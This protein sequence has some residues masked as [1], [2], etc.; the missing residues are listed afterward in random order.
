LVNV[1]LR[2]H[3]EIAEASAA[4]VLMTEA[5]IRLGLS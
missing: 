5:I 1:M 3:L 2:L 4:N